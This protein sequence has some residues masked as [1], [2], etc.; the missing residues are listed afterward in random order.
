MHFAFS[1]M[2]ILCFWI[3]W[4]FVIQILIE[5]FISSYEGFVVGY[6]K[7]TTLKSFLGF[8][9]IVK[10]LGLYSTTPWF[11]RDPFSGLVKKIDSK[12]WL[13]MTCDDISWKDSLAVWISFIDS[14]KKDPSVVKSQSSQARSLF[15]SPIH[16]KMHYVTM[17]GIT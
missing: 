4:I 3:L 2:H 14:I 9:M 8:Y 5:L 10:T 1:F 17:Q 13:R 6:S 12:I 7:G 15:S 16:S 11:I